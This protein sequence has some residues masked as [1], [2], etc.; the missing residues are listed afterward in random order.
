MSCIL[1]LVSGEISRLIKYKILP[2]SLVTSLLWII[3]FLFISKEDARNIAPLLIFVDVSMMSILLIGATLHLEKQEGTIKSM[4]VM[5]VSLG[6][7][8]VAKAFASIVLG[9]E[10]AIVTSAALFFIHGITFNY[11]LLL[12]FVFIAGAA[13]VAIGF[14]L[15]LSSKDFSSMLGLLMAYIFPFA[16]P[17]LLFTFGIIEEKYEWFIM[18]SPSHSASALITSVITSEFDWTK[19]IVGN[20]YLLILAAILFIFA[21]YP[22]FKNNAVRG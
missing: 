4:M 13:H 1:K 15:A 8:L 10:S 21:V 20:L 18:I 11:A 9:V 17:T 2:I 14:F 12:L 7:I 22:K 6:Q 16:I 19:I 3:I 5:P